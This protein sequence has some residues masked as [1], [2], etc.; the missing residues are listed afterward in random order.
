MAMLI[1]QTGLPPGVP[2]MARNDGTSDGATVT[3]TDTTP[4]GQTLFE[5]LWVHPDDDN[6]IQTLHA[7]PGDS[8]IWTFEPT[9]GVTGPIRIR[10]THTVNG[11]ASVETRIFGIPDDAGNVPPAPGERSDPNATVLNAED[12]LVIARCE[13]NWVTNEFPAGNP[14]GWAFDLA[15]AP[16]DLPTGPTGSAG[17]D[18]SGS[19]PDPTVIGFQSGGVGLTVGVIEDGQL[20]IRAGNEVIGFAG[21]RSEQAGGDLFGDYPAPNV[22][23]FHL[24]DERITYGAIVD[25][26]FLKRVGNEIVT[27]AISATPTGSAGGDLASSFPNPTVVKLHSGATQLSIGAIADGQMVV[28]SGANLLGQAQP[29]A[30][31]PNGSA[32]G[33]LAG[34]FPNPTVAALHSGATQL[35]VGAIAD[36]QMVVRSGSNL[37]GQAQ[38]SIPTALPPNGAAGGDLAGSFPN[39]TVA[40]LHSGATQLAVGTIVDG[41]FLKRVG[42][43][44]V[45]AVVSAA[46][47]G[48]AGGDLGG[49]YPSPTVVQ[50]HVNAGALALALGT[51]NDGEYLKRVGTS[52]VSAAPTVSTWTPADLSPEHWWRAGVT[53]Q[54]GGFVDTITDQGS[55]GRNFTAA[56]GNRA[57][58]GVDGNGKTFLIFNGSRIYVAGGTVADWK[59]L[60]DGLTPYTIML[61]MSKATPSTP[62]TEGI[63][64]TMNWASSGVG[65][66]LSR[67]YN[68]VPGYD[69]AVY[70]GTT[71]KFYLGEKRT[72][73]YAGIEV[74]GWTYAGENFIG[75]TSQL[76]GGP[77]ARN[78]IHQ[79]EGWRQGVCSIVEKVDSATSFPSINPQT[80]LTLGAFGDGNVK[81]TASVYDILIVKRALGPYEMGKYAE[82]A[83]ANANYNFSLRN[84]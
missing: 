69:F 36:G 33:D 28:R 43:T 46:P 42:N 84:A 27:E 10:L 62:V 24:P 45:S 78:I 2:G 48:S 56:G 20:L 1:D 59:W 49:T 4:G 67:G 70:N 80:V 57:A 14:F 12:P 15:V 55:G 61:V 32:G 21:E 58:V 64:C 71:S 6:T 83:S 19:Y 73:N 53:V 51:V 77:T 41:E 13:R 37:L 68:A 5:I 72:V 52:I 50:L 29:T 31:P 11:V 74:R 30:L 66:L 39:P 65:M 18:L 9:A 63:L 82:W 47:S 40:A 7:S 8:H 26:Q 23:A 22:I 60:S 3:L 35:S 16:P 44:I 76:N 75:H 81:L 17:G 38:P 25:G 79:V 54:S 34:S